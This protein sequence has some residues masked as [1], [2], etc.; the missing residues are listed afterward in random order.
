M[1]WP[2]IDISIIG[3][4]YF[5]GV[6]DVKINDTGRIGAY[7][8]YQQHI[9]TRANQT[10]GKK[11][12]DEV[13]FSAQAMELLGAQRSEEPNRAQRIEA[14]KNEVSSG[15]YHVDARELADKLLPFLR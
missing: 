4:F 5:S 7:R 8:T 6:I 11:R 12:K 15:T 9:E 1:L 3:L 10:A 2:I 14:L 13:Q